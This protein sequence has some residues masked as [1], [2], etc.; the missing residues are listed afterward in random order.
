MRIKPRPCPICGKPIPVRVTDDPFHY[1]HR[2]T[3]GDRA[4]VRESR[5]RSA[6]EN[7]AEKRIWL[8]LDGQKWP[9]EMQFADDPAAAAALEYGT[10][11]PPVT[12]VPRE[13]MT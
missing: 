5:S 13:A 12:H 6:A 8:P 7:E 10:V 2:A 9:A 1:A 11:R 3:C 4:C